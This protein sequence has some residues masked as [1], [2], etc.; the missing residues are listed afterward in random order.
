MKIPDGVSITH[1]AGIRKYNVH[2]LHVH[3]CQ[4]GNLNTIAYRQCS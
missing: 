1:A 4:N 3:V 2:Y